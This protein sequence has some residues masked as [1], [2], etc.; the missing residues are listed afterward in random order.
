MEEQKQSEP[1][2]KIAYKDLMSFEFSQAFQKIINKPVAVQFTATIRDWMKAID[3]IRKQMNEEY[4]KIF[5]AKYAL[6]D[7]KGEYIKAE[8]GQGYKSIEGKDEEIMK[9]QEIFGQTE[10]GFPIPSLNLA[11]L[12]HD[13]KLSA[14]EA[15]AMGELVTH[16]PI[17]QG[18]GVPQHAVSGPGKLPG[19]VTQ[20]RQ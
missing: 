6:K 13:F 18:P 3:K 8:N 4:D 10:V 1:Q 7:E 9:E 20:M 16:A 14:K 19:N 5:L 12:G 11:Y 17:E 15:L 2:I